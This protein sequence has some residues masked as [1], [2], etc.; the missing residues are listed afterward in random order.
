MKKILTGILGIVLVASIVS[1]SAYAIF[2]SQATLTGLTVASGNADITIG[3]GTAPNGVK[4]LPLN[5][6]DIPELYPGVV[7]TLPTNIWFH[8]ESTANINLS[9]KAQITS[10]S[11]PGAWNELADNVL[12]DVKNVTD[13]TGYVTYTL[14][15]W[16]TAPRVLPGNPLP[17]GPWATNNKEYEVRLRVPA[18]VGNEMANQVLTNIEM[19]ITGEQIL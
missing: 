8:N 9:V 16:N 10:W 18:S 2:S 6:I 19:T 3:D 14:R 11:A 4:T 7:Y 15:Q 17:Y 5:S 12:V 13:G 1:A